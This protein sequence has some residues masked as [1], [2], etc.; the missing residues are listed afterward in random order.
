M[1]LLVSKPRLVF[2]TELTTSVFGFSVQIQKRVCNYLGKYTGKSRDSGLTGRLV[3]T[4]DTQIKGEQMSWPELIFMELQPFLNSSPQNYATTT[5]KEAKRTVKRKGQA[6]FKYKF[7]VNTLSTR[8]A[9]L[10]VSPIDGIRCSS[11][12]QCQFRLRIKRCK[13]DQYQS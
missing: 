9:R 2:L 6:H 11:Q 7:S 3:W 8:H 13:D 5:T 12:E 1:P 4:S 10:C